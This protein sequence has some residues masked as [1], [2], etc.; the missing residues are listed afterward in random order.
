VGA[1][2]GTAGVAAAGA[3]LPGPSGPP[4]PP[5][6]PGFPAPPDP[7]EPPGVL[8]IVVCRFPT[9]RCEA[10]VVVAGGVFGLTVVIAVAAVIV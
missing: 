6:P 10:M 3:G 4:G 8:H 5:D 1:A 7:P 2:A 9:I